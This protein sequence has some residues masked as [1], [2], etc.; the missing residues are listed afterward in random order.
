MDLELWGPASLSASFHHSK[1]TDRHKKSG[2]L[3]TG[4][5]TGPDCCRAPAIPAATWLPSGTNAG[6][7]LWEA[8]VRAW[9]ARCPYPQP[10]QRDRAWERT[11]AGHP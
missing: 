11:I 9:A 7:D 8:Q 5:T 6:P 10:P 3:A 4:K 1:D 2:L